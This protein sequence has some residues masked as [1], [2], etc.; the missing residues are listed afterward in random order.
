MRKNTAAASLH[1]EAA[2]LALAASVGRAI[3]RLAAELGTSEKSIRLRIKRRRGRRLTHDDAALRLE[4]ITR[5]RNEGFSNIE[6]SDGL[7]LSYGLVG[8]IAFRLLQEGKI[9]YLRRGPRPQRKNGDRPGRLCARFDEVRQAREERFITLR[10]EGRTNREIAAALELSVTTV[11]YM[12]KELIRKGKIEARSGNEHLVA[13]GVCNWLKLDD[14]TTRTIIS[15]VKRRATLRQIGEAIG[16]TYERARQLIGHIAAKHGEGVFVLSEPIWTAVE[17]AKELKV[18][19]AVVNVVCASGD[20][21]CRRRGTTGRGHWLINDSGM[22]ALQR[23]PLVTQER[24][25]VVCGATFK[26]DGARVITCSDK[27]WGERRRRRLERSVSEQ[28]TLTSLAGWYRV[29]WQ[30]LQTH[31]IPEDDEWLGLGEAARRTGLSNM[32]LVWLRR[33]KVLTIRPHPLKVW[34]GR[35]V[36][37]YAA[38]ELEIVRRELEAR[39]CQSSKT[40]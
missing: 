15:L 31:S 35:P 25:C 10:H 27:C 21:S 30:E 32:Q 4:V 19:A 38:S 8:Q 40:L 39:G 17:A 20:V 5:L 3:K 11:A 33:R 13:N 29:L 23:H 34:R 7:R 37:L 18:T 26:H 14:C 2:K 24:T 6:I 22:K 28:P 16:V 9:A 36:A 12:A 1:A